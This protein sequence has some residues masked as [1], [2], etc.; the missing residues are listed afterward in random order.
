MSISHNGD[1][2]R[3][4]RGKEQNL[5]TSYTTENEKHELPRIDSYSKRA[6][7]ISLDQY[8]HESESKSFPHIDT[9]GNGTEVA[10]LLGQLEYDI[11]NNNVLIGKAATYS[12]MRESMTKFFASKVVAPDDLL[13]FYYSGHIIIDS[14]GELYL[15]AFDIDPNAP[16]QNALSFSEL[17][18]ILLTCLSEKI[19]IILDCTYGGRLFPQHNEDPEKIGI[20]VKAVISNKL[21][22]LK[23]GI[24]GLASA[25]PY[26]SSYASPQP[27]LSIFTYHLLDGLRG[28]ATTH[29]NGNITPLLLFEYV[30]SKSATSVFK[31]VNG[32][33]VSTAPRTPVFKFEHKCNIPL[34][35]YPQQLQNKRRPSNVPMQNNSSIVTDKINIDEAKNQVIYID[36]AVK[37]L[38]SEERKKSLIEGFMKFGMRFE[39]SLRYMAGVVNHTGPLQ[40][41]YDEAIDV[42]ATWLSGV[43]MTDKLSEDE[44][45]AQVAIAFLK[46]GEDIGGRFALCA[47][48]ILELPKGHELRDEALVQQS[49]LKYLEYCKLN[50]NIEGQLSMISKLDCKLCPVEQSLELIRNGEQV[51]VHSAPDIKRHF[52]IASLGYYAQLTIEARNKGDNEAQRQWL[53]ELEKKL[54]EIKKDKFDPSLHEGNLMA[55]GLVFDLTGRSEEAADTFALIVDGSSANTESFVRCAKNE[56]RIRIN[57]KQYNRAAYVLAKIVPALEERYLTAVEDDEIKQSGEDFFEVTNWLAFAHAYLD[58]WEDATMALEKGKSLRV[59]HLASL[60][61]SQNG[62]KLLDLEKYLYALSRGVPLKINE[63]EIDGASDWLGKKLSLK[64]KILEEYRASNPNYQKNYSTLHPSPKSRRTFCKENALSYSA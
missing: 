46:E 57:L 39:Y 55:A 41:L 54:D 18:S 2:A 64:T 49:L 27:G 1:L 63:F 10:K 44:R 21:L 32:N 11:E 47:D 58:E 59:R 4:N 17:N 56:G 14:Q 29:E 25:L 48:L 38:D 42:L 30:H 53:R 3:I 36:K 19:V 37:Y 20:Y 52:N 33:M 12:R 24:M 16:L 22:A 40:F 13:L 43:K 60:H 6:L 51:L 50:G 28:K 9:R 15:T 23:K 45:R 34:A 26:E 61:Q 7:V 62:G 35:S 31:Q 8:E 5:S